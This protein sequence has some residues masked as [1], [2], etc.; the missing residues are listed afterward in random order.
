MALVSPPRLELAQR[1]ERG[2][3]L[4]DEFGPHAVLIVERQTKALRLGADLRENLAAH[5]RIACV[6]RRNGGE[7]KSK[8]CKET[9]ENGIGKAPRA[10]NANLQLALVVV[11]NDA[12]RLRVHFGFL[13][14]PLEQLDNGLAS[15]A[16]VCVEVGMAVPYES[17]TEWV[18]T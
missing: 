4:R 14:E 17:K 2:T 1:G 9:L 6:W 16:C 15:V 11:A 18:D 12:I 10:E 8:R 3:R 5:K 13:L 7:G